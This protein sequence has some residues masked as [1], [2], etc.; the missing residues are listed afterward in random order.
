MGVLKAKQLLTIIGIANTT[1]VHHN[2]NSSLTI[3][4]STLGNHFFAPSL[5]RTIVSVGVLIPTQ[6]TRFGSLVLG[7]NNMDLE[8]VFKGSILSLDEDALRAL[9]SIDI[10]DTRR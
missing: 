10:L 2:S 3:P 9:D 5:W 6:S 1:L 7:I 8:E 4:K